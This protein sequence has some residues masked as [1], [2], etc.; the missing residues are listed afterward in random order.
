MRRQ[1]VLVLTLAA[2]GGT[3]AAQDKGEEVMKQ[4][5]ERSKPVAEHERLDALAGS[6]KQE[7]V[8]H[9]P[10]AGKASGRSVNRW[11]LGRRF[12][13]CETVG[14]SGP[15]YSEGLTTLG[16]DVRKKEYF[17][18]GIDT[19]GTA[20]V[21]PH[22]RWDEAARS[23]VLKGEWLDDLSG[24]PY[25]FT[26]TFRIEGKDRY[27]YELVFDVPNQPPLKVLEITHTRE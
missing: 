18:L 8:W 21:N 1:A 7:I 17:A 13:Q 24:A 26:Q 10:A 22:G 9:A 25:A 11:I 5:A 14:G 4:Y 23:F 3:L 15:F 2:A 27:V 6:W 12:L 16:Y 19:M 20:Y